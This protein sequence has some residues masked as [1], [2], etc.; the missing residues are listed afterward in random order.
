MNSSIGQSMA[1][2]AVLL[3]AVFMLGLSIVFNPLISGVPATEVPTWLS[4]FFAGL[5]GVM[6]A[7]LVQLQNRRIRELERALL[8]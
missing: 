8:K 3:L 2:W 5:L 1:T 7:A 6:V 4:F